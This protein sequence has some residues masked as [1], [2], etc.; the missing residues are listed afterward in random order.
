VFYET[1][2]TII[3]VLFLALAVQGCAYDTLALRTAPRLAQRV[4]AGGTAGAVFPSGAVS[5]TTS[6]GASG[7]AARR[8]R[9]GET[10]K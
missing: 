5:P 8:R 6:G 9:C 3:P 4:A 10:Q 1:A 7:T 2:A